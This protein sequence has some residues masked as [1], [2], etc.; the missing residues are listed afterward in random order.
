MSADVRQGT[1]DVASFSLASSRIWN[2]AL[3][4]QQEKTERH[5]CVV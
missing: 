2:D 4:A 1:P 5:R 3:G